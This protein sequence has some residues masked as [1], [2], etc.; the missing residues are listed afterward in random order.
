[1]FQKDSDK[2]KEQRIMV[3][4]PGLAGSKFYVKDDAER[5]KLNNLPPVPN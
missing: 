4:K 3:L 5:E 1:M 2:P